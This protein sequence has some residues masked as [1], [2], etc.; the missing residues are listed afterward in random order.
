MIRIFTDGVVVKAKQDNPCKTLSMNLAHGKYWVSVLAAVTVI[1]KQR[2][3][4]IAY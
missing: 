4:I 3:Y 1:L 2:K